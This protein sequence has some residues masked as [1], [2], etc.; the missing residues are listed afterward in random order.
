MNRGPGRFSKTLQG[1]SLGKLA[2]PSLRR[3]ESPLQP[4]L[5]HRCTS[6]PIFSP[7]KSPR[8][9]PVLNTHRQACHGSLNQPHKNQKTRRIYTGRL[10]FSKLLP[11]L[12]HFKQQTRVWWSIFWFENA[13]AEYLHGYHGNYQVA[14]SCAWSWDCQQE[15][16]YSSILFLPGLIF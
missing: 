8:I 9:P 14:S 10:P 11:I 6:Y 2:S 4:P 3:T 13:P 12:F 1:Y 16:P 15:S 7:W 5:N